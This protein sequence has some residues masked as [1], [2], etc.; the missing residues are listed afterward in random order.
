MPV[1]ASESSRRTYLIVYLPTLPPT[2][3]TARPAP[4]SIALPCGP[5]AP[6]SGTL[7]YTV[8]SLPETL[9]PPLLL[10]P[11]DP[12]APTPT[13]SA[14]T[15]QPLTAVLRV[16]NLSP[17]SFSACQRRILA[18]RPEGTQSRA[19]ALSLRG[20]RA[21]RPGS[22]GRRRIGGRRRSGRVRRRRSRAPGT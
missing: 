22:A 13:A 17:S 11:L 1:E 18:P 9:P 16:S 3:S 15:R 10:E 5:E 6:C 12:Q 19:V 20:S 14:A 4:F 2:A 21:G 8:S 7:A